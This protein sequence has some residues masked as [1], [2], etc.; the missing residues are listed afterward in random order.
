[1]KMRSKSGDK[2]LA[3]M[4]TLILM[5]E[6]NMV[7]LGCILYGNGETD[8]ITTFYVNIAK[9]VDHKNEVVR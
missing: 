6:P 5:C 7:S 9:S 4:Y 8:I 2:C 1:M 3:D